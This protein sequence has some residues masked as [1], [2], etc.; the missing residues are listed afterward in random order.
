MAKNKKDER[1]TEKIISGVSRK[2]AMDGNLVQIRPKLFQVIVK[3]EIQE[4]MIKIEDSIKEEVDVE[5]PLA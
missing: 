4:P 2:R 1:L 5:D 3:D